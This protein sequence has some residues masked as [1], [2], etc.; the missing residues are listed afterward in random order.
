MNI[1]RKIS[2][3]FSKRAILPET[4]GISRARIKRIV[5]NQSHGNIRLQLGKFYTK[6]D[7]DKRYEQGQR[8]KIQY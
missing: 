6:K 2:L 3:A 4:D 5:A 1:L 8:I 7:A